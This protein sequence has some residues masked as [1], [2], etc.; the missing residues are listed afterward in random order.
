MSVSL[1]NSKLLKLSIALQAAL[2]LPVAAFGATDP[3]VRGGGPA[4]GGVLPGLS[5]TE[6]Q[7]FQ[8]AADVFAEVDGVEEG[9][10]PRFNMD[11]CAG[12]HAQPAMGG[13]APATNPQ[14]AVATKNGARNTIPSFITLNGPVREA[15]FVRNADG[16][17]DGG[18]HGLFTINGRTDAPGCNLPQPNFATQVSNNNVIFRIPTPVFGAGLIE[19]ISEEAIVANK[20]SSANATLG[21]SGKENRNGNDGTIT[22]FG[23]KAQNKSLNIFS[24]EAYN[25]EQG[26][27]NP[28]FP[29]ERD[30]GQ[31]FTACFFNALPESGVNFDAVGTPDAL[32]DVALFSIFM[33]FLAPPTPSTTTP[34]GSN[35]I[36]QGRNQFVNIGCANC[37]TPSFTTA[38]AAS[39]ALSQKPVNLFSDLLLHNMGPGLAD[40]VSQGLAGGDEFR[41]A[42]LWGLGQRIFFLH[43]GRTT[44]LLTAIAAHKSAANTQFPASEANRVIDNFN[45]LADSDKQAIL[46]FLRSL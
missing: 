4:A 27:T 8:T 44:N 15:R 45:A 5:P 10:G 17:A 3:G 18:V 23:W 16:T 24:G 22:R 42:P 46:N 9:L 1:P 28:L 29:N 41:S 19:L 36:T 40:R 35:S 30:T 34:G 37:H 43:D 12:C 11:S 26:V 6:S 32:G 21:I 25:V 7:F 14:I 39:A 20:T 38:P 33:Q 31:A 2:I 13:S